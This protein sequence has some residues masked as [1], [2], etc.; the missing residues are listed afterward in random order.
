MAMCC[1]GLKEAAPTSH[2][3]TGNMLME[4][5][6]TSEHSDSDTLMVVIVFSVCIR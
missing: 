5:E 4:Y 2:V 6:I 3:S 1:W